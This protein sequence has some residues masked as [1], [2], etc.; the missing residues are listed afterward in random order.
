MSVGKAMLDEGGGPGDPAERTLFSAVITPHRS[1]DP[2]SFRLM[3]VLL[4]VVTGLLA[5]RF[6]AFGFWPVAGFLG[7]DVLGLYIAF[8][9]SYRRGRAFEE[10]R[11][12][13]IEL[14]LRHVSHRGEEREWRLNPL[15]TKLVR[16]THAEFGLQRLTLVSRGERIVIAGE[17]SP[18]ERAHFAD[19]FGD[20]LGRAKRGLGA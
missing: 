18:G 13:P 8:K 11:L 19:A 20:A 1:L 7:L 12:T 9:V 6:V 14:L 17:L 2:E 3:M 5:L 15:W 16:E 10:V 4:C